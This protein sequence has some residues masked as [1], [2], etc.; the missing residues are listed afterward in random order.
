MR[1][2]MD[3]PRL[4]AG[5]VLLLVDGPHGPHRATAGGAP[6]PL[7]H[8]HFATALSK[9]PPPFMAAQ[10]KTLRTMAVGNFGQLL[11]AVATDPAMMLYLDNARNVAGSPNENYAR[12]LL[13]LHTLGEGN[14]TETD[15]KQIARRSPAGSSAAGSNPVASPPSATTTAS[16]RSSARA[17]TSISTM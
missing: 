5:D 3:M 2:D 14:Y 10:N 11:R 17:A 8:D 7:W 4:G 9:A 16:R 12:E 6:D 13:E 1:D 15:I